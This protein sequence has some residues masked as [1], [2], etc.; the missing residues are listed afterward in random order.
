[1]TP[2]ESAMN[3]CGV[4]QQHRR[5]TIREKEKR[6]RERE[7]EEKEDEERMEK[8]IHHSEDMTGM[9]TRWN[10]GRENSLYVVLSVRRELLFICDGL[11]AKEGKL[12]SPN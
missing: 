2:F 5:K 11:T 12:I 4:V 1:M 7:R 9:K 6:G 3:L 10:S 8:K